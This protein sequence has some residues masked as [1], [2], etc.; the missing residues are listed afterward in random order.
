MEEYREDSG[1]QA[2]IVNGIWMALA[3]HA[4]FG[5]FFFVIGAYNLAAF[6]V[7]SVSLYVACFALVRRNLVTPAIIL[8]MAEV[9]V[10]A[11]LAV[12][13]LGWD[14]GFQYY[15]FALVLLAFFHPHWPVIGKISFLAV[16]YLA[17][18]ALDLRMAGHGATTVV[19]SETIFLARNFNIVSTCGCI[20]FLAY[21]YTR[22]ARQAQSKLEHLAA[23]DMLTGLY[24]RR[25]LLEIAKQELTRLQRTGGSLA[26]IMA[27]ID[28]FKAINDGFGHECGDLALKA[29]AAC[30]KETVRAQDHVAR[31]GGEEFLL[32]LPDTRLPGAHVLA[33]KVREAV[34]STPIHY[35]N[36]SFNITLTAG[37]I[38]FSPKDDFNRSLSRVDNALLEGKR[39]GK[40]RVVAIP[41]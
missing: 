37:V 31:W 11:W 30:L 27:D 8:T 21:T 39:T 12:T 22:V 19:S 35:E 5:I 28:D 23:T 25:R 10:H 32:L 38:E 24:N 3:I 1:Y 4:L 33:D 2:L 40:N 14:G 17:Y 13:T 29:I 20:A 16:T 26:I 15:I 6:N 36:T 34:S 18:L 9:I 7:G 41:A